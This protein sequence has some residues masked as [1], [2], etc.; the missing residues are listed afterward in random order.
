MRHFW[1]T[2]SAIFLGVA[3]AG[4]VSLGPAVP[5]LA[6]PGDARAR[7]VVVDLSASVAG[8]QVVSANA[9]IGTA[10]APAAGG[11]DT[12]TALAIALPGAVGVT[13][14]GTVVQVSATRGPN[15]SSANASI[16]DLA[17][18]ILGTP[19]LAAEAIT[20][21]VN[22]PR[23]GAQSAETTLVGLE[24][25]GAPVAVAPN[26]P[27]VDASTAVVVAGLVGATLNASVTRVETTTA[28]GATA[29]AV[30]AS[31]TLTGTVAGVPVTIPVGTVILAEATCQ[32]PAAVPPPGPPQPPAPGPG[33]P[34]TGSSIGVLLSLGAAL[35]AAGAMMLL[36]HRRR[37]RPTSFVA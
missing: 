24:L 29:I 25:F 1:R 21:T 11:T 12:S 10:T 27:A 23:V 33:L 19:V 28:T 3:V 14:T 35:V 16:A 26:T 9:T 13:A 17:L 32:R 18:G 36:I 7:G 15:A 8:V 4:A 34:V 37:S 30:Q 5:A 31:F 2:S 6:A 22:C 20:A